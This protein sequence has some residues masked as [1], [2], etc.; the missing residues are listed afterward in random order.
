[1][2]RGL[3]FTTRVPFIVSRG[4]T[5]V[6]RTT[7]VPTGQDTQRTSLDD[8]IQ[9]SDQNETC[10]HECDMTSVGRSFDSSETEVVT[11][12]LERRLISEPSRSRAPTS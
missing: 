6:S 2:A 3:P 12:T 1:M 4:L 11:Q 7:H 9:P 8:P 5:M 10:C